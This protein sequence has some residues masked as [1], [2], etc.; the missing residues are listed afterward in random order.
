VGRSSRVRRGRVK[1]ERNE[2]EDSRGIRAVR[3][4]I[5]RGEGKEGEG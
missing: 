4:K 2:G 3:R 1:G 5:R